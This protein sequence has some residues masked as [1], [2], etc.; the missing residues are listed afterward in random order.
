MCLPAVL[1]KL[2]I[3]KLS[4]SKLTVVIESNSSSSINNVT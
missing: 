4:L 3:G 2:I 1:V